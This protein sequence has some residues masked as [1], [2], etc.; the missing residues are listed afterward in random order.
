MWRLSNEKLYWPK[1]SLSIK[2]PQFWPN[3]AEILATL[4]IHGIVSLTKFYDKRTK[5]VDFSLMISF[6]LT[7]QCRILISGTFWKKVIDVLPSLRDFFWKKR[8]RQ[9][10]VLTFFH[11]VLVLVS[12]QYNQFL[13][14]SAYYCSKSLAL[15]VF[16]FCRVLSQIFEM[17]LI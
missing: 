3:L 11:T 6:A 4:P 12:F 9:I 17:I 16:Q 8:H 2:N 1:N 13:V 5:T 10:L 14:H 15:Y 7:N